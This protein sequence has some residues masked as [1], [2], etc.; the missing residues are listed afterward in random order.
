MRYFLHSI[1]IFLIPIIGYIIIALAFHDS[2]NTIIYGINTENQIKQSFRNVLKQE[3]ELLVLGNSRCYRGINPDN[4][5]VSAFNFSHDN[6][7]YN[8]IFH[9]LKY[10]IDNNKIPRSLV[11][12]VDYFQFSFKS[13]TRNYT[14]GKLLGKRFLDDYKYQNINIY[15]LENYIKNSLSP[16]S[17]FTSLAKLM[18]SYRKHAFLK[19]NGQFIC[20]GNAN[21]RETIIRDINRIS[22]QEDYFK[23]ILDLC[24]RNDMQIFLIM[25]PVRD[26]E[27]SS[28]SQEQIDEFN[29]YINQFVSDNLFYINFSKDASFVLSDFTDIT[30]LNKEAADVFTSKL[31]SIIVNKR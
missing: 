5:S 8:V 11:L 31:D 10:C 23:E 21:P 3:N 22:F 4:F 25:P 28:Y 29:N 1:L 24:E 2:I 15:I 14:Y 7:S 16:K 26:N 27:L 17:F 9:K 13:S 30:H 12:G 20:P 6:D 18:L 19:Q